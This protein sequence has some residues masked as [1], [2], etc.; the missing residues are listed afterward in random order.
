MPRQHARERAACHRGAL[1]GTCPAFERGG[2]VYC[3]AS[4]GVFWQPSV[5]D[6]PK[7]DH[8]ESVPGHGLELVEVAVVPARIGGARNEPA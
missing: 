3:G 2:S 6:G 4:E 8:L 5:Q 1:H 7:L